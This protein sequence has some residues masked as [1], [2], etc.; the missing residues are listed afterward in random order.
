MA[1]VVFGLSRS[2]WLTFFCLALTAP[3]DTVSTVIRNI[4]RQ[5][6]TPDRLRGR[7]TG[8]NMVFFMGG[9]QLGEFEAGAV[10]SWLGATVCGHRRRGLPPRD[11]LGSG[12]D[13]TAQGVLS[14]TPA[15]SGCDGV[16][17]KVVRFA[18]NTISGPS[19]SG[20]GLSHR[21]SGRSRNLAIG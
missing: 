9:P 10:A 5:L 17:S 3:A 7:M 1:T 18:K 13:A 21:G 15:P 2:F 4:I 11:R 8:V 14:P 16:S 20:E 12:H 19:S 6:E